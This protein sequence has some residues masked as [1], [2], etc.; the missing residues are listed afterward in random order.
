MTFP[1]YHPHSILPGF[2]QGR[3]TKLYKRLYC[4][5]KYYTYKEKWI[6]GVSHFCDTNHIILG[7]I[8]FNVGSILIDIAP[9]SDSWI[10]CVVVD[11]RYLYF[12][13]VYNY[14]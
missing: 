8:L 12:S 3:Q 10:M 5:K 7:L 6:Q 9:V 11:V 1:K 14:Q 4:P 2:L 13:S